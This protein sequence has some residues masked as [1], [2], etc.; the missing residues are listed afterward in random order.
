M[1]KGL[2][3]QA[4]PANAIGGANADVK[5]VADEYNEGERSA[6]AKKAAAGRRG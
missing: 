3:R 5:A 4:R 1:L 6:I 2:Q